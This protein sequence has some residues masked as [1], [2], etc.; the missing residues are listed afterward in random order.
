MSSDQVTHH[1]GSGPRELALYMFGL[2][3]AMFGLLVAADPA[4]AAI[5]FSDPIEGYTEG[6]NWYAV[7]PK[8]TLIRGNP[9][10]VVADGGGGK[11][12]VQALGNV[13]DGSASVLSVKETS[14]ARYGQLLVRAFQNYDNITNFALMSNNVDPVFAGIEASAVVNV[15]FHPY[16][17]VQYDAGNGSYTTWGEPRGAGAQAWRNYTM[18]YDLVGLTWQLWFDNTLVN[19]AIPMANTPASVTSIALGVAQWTPSGNYPTSLDGVQ[20]LVSADT[21]FTAPGVMVVPEPSLMGLLGLGILG[22]LQR[23]KKA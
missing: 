3:S 10:Q 18:N 6:A 13:S 15:Q 7:N 8:V 14:S 4:M 19:G 2:L 12:V 17:Y 9:S 21:P 20:W 22:I 1:N 5:M 16:G 23:S 11:Q